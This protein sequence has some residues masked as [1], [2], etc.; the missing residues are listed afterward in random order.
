MFLVGGFADS[1][2]LQQELKTEFSRR[3][4]ILIPHYTTI[5]AVQGAVNFGKKP[6]Q[7]FERVA[8]ATLGADRSIDFI[9]GVHPEEKK[10]ITGVIEKCGQLFKCFV[11]ENSV[12]KFGERI[13]RTY[14]PVRTNAKSLKFGFYASQVIPKHSLLLTPW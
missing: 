4:R 12:V 6:A 14:H 10:F 1:A 9:E 7:I 3:L 8:S 5:A 13:T 11:R 2:F